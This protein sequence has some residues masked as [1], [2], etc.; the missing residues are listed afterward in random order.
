MT[1]DL[2]HAQFRKVGSLADELCVDCEQWSVGEPTDDGVQGLGIGD[3][4]IFG[5]T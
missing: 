5:E 3:E 4:R 2:Q 1:R